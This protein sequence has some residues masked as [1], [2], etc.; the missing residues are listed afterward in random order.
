MSSTPTVYRSDDTSAPTITRELNSLSDLLEAI[1]VDGYGAKSDAGWTTEFTAT[2]KKVFRNSTTNGTGVYLR[3]DDSVIISSNYGLAKVNLFDTVSDIDTGTGPCPKTSTDS[4]IQSDQAWFEFYGTG[5]S[6]TTTEMPW[7]CV[8][9]DR[10][11]YLSISSN[12]TDTGS[13][14]T[15]NFFKASAFSGDVFHLWAGDF[16]SYLNTD[17][18]AS[19]VSVWNAQSGSLPA[20]YSANWIDSAAVG[21]GHYSWVK[22][23][24]DR[25][26]EG[27]K[28]G[29]KATNNV[30]TASPGIEAQFNVGIRDN[31][32]NDYTSDMNSQHIFSPVLMMEHITSNQYVVRGMFRGLFDGPF[33][34]TTGVENYTGETKT[35]DSVDLLGVRVKNYLGFWIDVTADAWS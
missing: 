22:R 19:F 28:V 31:L 17:G 5:T 18:Y 29:P 32:S 7:I 13:T 23:G 20:C 30:S 10:T 2:G 14:G 33:Y 8:A 1:L 4:S 9:D 25:S 35:I 26:T 16:D 3:V 15:P 12:A 24:V 27:T 21:T 11:F 6:T 34:G